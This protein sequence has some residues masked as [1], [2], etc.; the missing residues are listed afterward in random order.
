MEK[1]LF[2]LSGLRA[3]ITGSSQGIGYAL[4]RGLAEAGAEIILNGR[5]AEKLSIAAQK[6][7]AEGHTVHQSSFDVTDHASVKQHIDQIEETI[8]AIDILISNA[9][10]QKRSPLEDFSASDWT[11]LMKTNLDGV[12]NTGQ[13]VANHMIKRKRG[14]IINICSVQSSLA[15]PTIAPYTASKGAVAMLTKGMCTD[16]AK[17]NIQINGIAPGYFETEL[18]QALVDDEAFTAWLENRTPAKRWGKVEELIGS[19][20]FLSSEASSFIN[21]HILYVDGGI[22]SSL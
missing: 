7:S 12:F 11:E 10:I 4:A 15:R 1:T 20:I 17:Y 3:L 9:G 21:G 2:D 5:N 14:K 19:A 16:W 13:A 22:T 6:L 8:G 18:N